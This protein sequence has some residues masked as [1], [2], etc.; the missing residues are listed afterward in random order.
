MGGP[1]M[2]GLSL[3]ELLVVAFVV[4]VLVLTALLAVLLAT[5]GGRGTRPGSV[6]LPQTLC[7]S[8]RGAVEAADKFCRNC[9]AR[10]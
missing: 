8:C 5:R 1:S 4:G 2:F 6:Y 10:L 7:G 9:G 3:V